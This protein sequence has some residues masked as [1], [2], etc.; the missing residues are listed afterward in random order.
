MA[1]AAGGGAVTLHLLASLTSLATCL[2]VLAR[3]G[4]PYLG[5]LPV[6]HGVRAVGAVE[7]R[8]VEGS[9]SWPVSGSSSLPLSLSA[10][11][12]CLAA[13]SNGAWRRVSNLT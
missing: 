10:E 4:T 8:G 13:A 2:V 7:L 11:E 12:G 3:L 5:S 1:A 9:S 6:L